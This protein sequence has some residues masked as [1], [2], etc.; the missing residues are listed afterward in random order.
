VL[1]NPG[2]L[3][4]MSRRAPCEQLIKIVQYYQGSAPTSGSISSLDS[5]SHS[6][7]RV[8]RRVLHRQILV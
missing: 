6:A 1:H 4:L 8:E 7:S 2:L 5:Y 3:K